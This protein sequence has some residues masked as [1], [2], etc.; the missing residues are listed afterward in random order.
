MVLTLREIARDK[1]CSVG[2]FFEKLHGSNMN[3]NNSLSHI[4]ACLITCALI[5]ACLKTDA[6][7]AA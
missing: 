4:A 3:V 5:N 6:L 2:K 7:I 1:V